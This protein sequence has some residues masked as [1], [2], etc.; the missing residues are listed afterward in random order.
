MELQ[1]Q[2]KR[3]DGADEQKRLRNELLRKIIQNEQR[4]KAQAR[5]K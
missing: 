5:P 1:K 2:A 4:R 3:K